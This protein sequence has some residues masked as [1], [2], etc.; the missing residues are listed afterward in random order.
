MQNEETVPYLE[1][2]AF[3]FFVYMKYAI[4]PAIIPKSIT[5]ASTR[6]I[7]LIEFFFIFFTF[8]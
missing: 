4:A 6:H 7:I 8:F 1:D 5:P 3:A 2:S